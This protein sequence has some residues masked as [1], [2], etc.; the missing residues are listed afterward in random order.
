MCICK[1]LLFQIYFDVLF[2]YRNEVY[3][4]Y[5]HSDPICIIKIHGGN[6]K[7]HIII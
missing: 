6:I 3:H 5:M 7:Q 4:F 2:Y 1:V